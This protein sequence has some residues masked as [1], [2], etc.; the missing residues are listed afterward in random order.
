MGRATTAAKRTE[1]VPL[2]RLTPLQKISSIAYDMEL[3]I[4]DAIGITRTAQE[5]ALEENFEEYDAAFGLIL[6]R[7]G[8]IREGHDLIAQNAPYG[9]K[10]RL[11]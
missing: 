8:Q 9:E 3:Q 10:E 4:A 5:K 1:T 6:Y 11:S 2:E 7:L